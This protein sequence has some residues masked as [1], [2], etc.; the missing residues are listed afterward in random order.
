MGDSEK[1]EAKRVEVQQIP[2]DP[3][4]R[5]LLL[6]RGL[7]SGAIVPIKEQFNRWWASGDPVLFISVMPD[8][9]V[10]FVRMDDEQES[11]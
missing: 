11:G 7:P 3:D 9:E 4:G 2:I 10:E 6:I 8:V 1:P 5:Y